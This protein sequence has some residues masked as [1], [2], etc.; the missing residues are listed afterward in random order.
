MRRALILALAALIA[1]AAHSA[2]DTTV[3]IVN[4]T[5]Y[6]GETI[7]AAALEEVTLKR[8]PNSREAVATAIEDL[9]GRVARRTLLPRRLIP[10]SSVREA[11]LVER[12]SSVRV[13]FSAG[14]LTISAT[15][16]PLES[17]GAGDLI[18]VR[19]V[20]SGAVFSGTVMADGT[21]RV[22]AT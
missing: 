20:D 19:N 16:V 8:A 12:G 5:I 4:R 17:G 18:K 11:W 2:A 1:S 22:G 14:A 13:V 10:L 7:P 15:A 21:V 3:A 9:E 6:P